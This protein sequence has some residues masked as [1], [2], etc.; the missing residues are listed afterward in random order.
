[1]SIVK[2]ILSSWTFPKSAFEGVPNSQDVQIGA[3]ISSPVTLEVLVNIRLG[4][5]VPFSSITNLLS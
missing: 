3:V 2:T 1:M 4:Q 5:V